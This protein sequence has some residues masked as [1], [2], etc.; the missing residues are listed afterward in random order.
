MTRM[1]RTDIV[2]AQWEAYNRGDIDSFLA[3]IAP[4]CEFH[5]DPAF[6]EA[7]VYRGPEEIRAYLTQ[8]REAMA[9]HW[10][11]I[12]EVRDLGNAVIAL[13]HERARGKTSG[14]EVDIRPAFVCRFR[15]DKIVWARAYLDRAEALSEAELK[16][17]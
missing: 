11:E 15:G 2:R 3:P 14:V 5:E 10:F 1:E 17:T 9:D 8:F 13:L 6:P 7:G 12:E 4:D 16:S